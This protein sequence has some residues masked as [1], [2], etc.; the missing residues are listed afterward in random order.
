MQQETLS[1]KDQMFE[2]RGYNLKGGSKY[3]FRKQISRGTNETSFFV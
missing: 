2:L 1:F 3:E